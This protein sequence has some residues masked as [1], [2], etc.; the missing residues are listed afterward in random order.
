MLEM[1]C[2][3]I[4]RGIRAW[5]LTQL[6]GIFSVKLGFYTEDFSRA[7]LAYTFF[8]KLAQCVKYSV[9]LRLFKLGNFIFF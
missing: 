3:V 8:V 4:K 7:R 1:Q 5:H 9:L 6:Y 2:L